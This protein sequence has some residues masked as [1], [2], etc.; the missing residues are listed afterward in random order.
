MLSIFMSSFL[1]NR[2][3]DKNEH[4]IFIL[5]Y[6]TNFTGDLKTKNID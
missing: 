1:L 6:C 2:D 5:N 3:H 4:Q